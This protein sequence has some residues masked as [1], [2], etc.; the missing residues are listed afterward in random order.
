M[1][2]SSSIR[3]APQ[4]RHASNLWAI[5]HWQIC[6][7][8]VMLTSRICLIPGRSPWC[9]AVRSLMS[10]SLG[11]GF[12]LGRLPR[13]EPDERHQG[14]AR[15]GR[16]LGLR[17]IARWRLGRLDLGWRRVVGHLIT[18]TVKEGDPLY[19]LKIII[20]HPVFPAVVAL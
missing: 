14:G 17:R 12:L 11:P 15:T 7:A 5:A 1:S 16:H 2:P 20:R 6:W 9:V 3:N 19:P 10:L 4:T 13:Q 18:R 8:G